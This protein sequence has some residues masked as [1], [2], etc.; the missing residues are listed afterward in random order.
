[1]KRKLFVSIVLWVLVVLVLSMFSSC[2]KKQRNDEDVV[3][4]VPITVDDKSAVPSVPTAVERIVDYEISQDVKKYINPDNEHIALIDNLYIATKKTFDNLLFDD[5]ISDAATELAEKTNAIINAVMNK[6]NNSLKAWYAGTYSDV[7]GANIQISI[8]GYE[9]TSGII[10]R[11]TAFYRKLKA[12]DTIL[13]FYY[14]DYK[15]IVTLQ[16]YTTNEIIA[17]YSANELAADRKYKNKLIV[18][19]GFVKEITKDV[20]DEYY[21]ALGDFSQISDELHCYFDSTYEDAIVSIDSGSYVSFVVSIT[22][23]GV[24][25]VDA[26]LWYINPIQNAN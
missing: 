14:K 4:S 10:S 8:A 17:D 24:F 21:I 20:F 11:E 13:G 22:E 7:I 3:P 9:N 1:M 2:S 6:E 26:R 5:S 23:K 12:A 25:D 19:N 16:E 18:V 15:P